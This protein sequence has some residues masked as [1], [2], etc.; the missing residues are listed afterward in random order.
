M[1]LLDCTKL[2]S[3]KKAR[4]AGLM[5]TDV[6]SN[7]ASNEYSDTSNSTHVEREKIYFLTETKFC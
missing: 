6:N 5:K 7:V 3:Q 2:L 1:H 4:S